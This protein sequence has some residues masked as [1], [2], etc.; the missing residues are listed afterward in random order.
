MISIDCPSPIGIAL[1]SERVG[2]L[3]L[4]YSRAN[5][6]PLGGYN[7]RISDWNFHKVL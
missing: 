3:V 4:Q 1:G 6:H 7:L 5:F 2:R